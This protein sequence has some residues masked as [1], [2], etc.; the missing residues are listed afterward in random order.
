MEPNQIIRVCKVCNTVQPINQFN[1]N[2]NKKNITYRHTCKECEKINKRQANK[3]YYETVK[4]RKNNN[5]NLI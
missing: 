4:A 1:T 3:R 2:R 5:N